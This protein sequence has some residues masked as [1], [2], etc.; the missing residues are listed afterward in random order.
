MRDHRA[1]MQDTE[2][3]QVVQALEILQRRIAVAEQRAA[4]LE[5]LLSARMMNERS[6][7]FLPE[8]L[9]AAGTRVRALLSQRDSLLARLDRLAPCP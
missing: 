5:L 4:D 9:R 7:Q 6:I 1:G 2:L 8:L 3:E